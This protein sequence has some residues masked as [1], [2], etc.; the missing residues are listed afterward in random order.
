MIRLTQDELVRLVREGEKDFRSADLTGL[1]LFKAD[2]QR[3]N[4][5]G[6]CLRD[7]KMMQ[8]NLFK[9]D[10]EGADLQGASLWDA[11]ASHAD[12]RNSNFRNVAAREAVFDSARFAGAHVAGAVFDDSSLRHAELSELKWGNADAPSVKNA[13]INLATYK[14]SRWKIDDLRWWVHH[15]ALVAGLDEF[16]ELLRQW[17]LR[18]VAG[19]T[20]YFEHELR[21][22]DADAI[23]ELALDIIGADAECRVAE[24]YQCDGYSWL[25]LTGADASQLEKVARALYERSK[26]NSPRDSG[27][28]GE[29]GEILP[30]QVEIW[31]PDVKEMLEDAAAKHTRLKDLRLVKTPLQKLTGKV[32]DAI[33]KR[34]SS[35]LAG[36]PEELLGLLTHQDQDGE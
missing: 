31:T 17:L 35:K 2:L 10:F 7:T 20:L 21:L 8:T 16:P 25:R 3:A 12:F 28:Q 23:H 22:N 9:C 27:A 1:N 6:A 14:N 13:L 4:F 29:N 33:L 32:S 36:L 5:S 30:H 11:L 15:G 18:E 19:L 24:Y 26:P 34:I